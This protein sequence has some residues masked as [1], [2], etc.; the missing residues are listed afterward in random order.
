[1]TLRIDANHYDYRVQWSREDGKYVGTC[2]EYP[3][4]SW[5]DDTPERALKGIIAAVKETV[6]QLW[7][8]EEYVTLPFSERILP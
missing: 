7:E 5:M 3:E 6:E 4:L 1:M 8:A 2:R